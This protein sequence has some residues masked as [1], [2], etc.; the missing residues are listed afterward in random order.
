PFQERGGK[1]LTAFTGNDL[2]DFVDGFGDK[3][4]NIDLFYTGDSVIGAD[5]AG[6]WSTSLERPWRYIG[7]DDQLGFKGGFGYNDPP[8][9]PPWKNGPRQACALFKWE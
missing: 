3:I 8:V 5:G 6:S 9:F 2:I 4:L 7:S 1:N